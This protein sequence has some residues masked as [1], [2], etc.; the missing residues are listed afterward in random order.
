MEKPCYGILRSEKDENGC[1]SYWLNRN[2]KEGK[3]ID[4]TKWELFYY[5]GYSV[6]DWIE[7]V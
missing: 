7:R 2:G 1:R 6:L 4:L 3:R 5:S